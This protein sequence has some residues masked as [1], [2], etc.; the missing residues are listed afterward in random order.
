M[1]TRD[2]L[3]RLLFPLSNS[4][5]INGNCCLNQK[6]IYGSLTAMI[7]WSYIH[8]IYPSPLNGFELFYLVLLEVVLSVI[9]YFNPINIV[10]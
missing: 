1:E 9:I 10:K 5:K 6:W 2:F 3:R 7:A 4:I 8:M